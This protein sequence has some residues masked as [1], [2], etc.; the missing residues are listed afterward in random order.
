[1]MPEESSRTSKCVRCRF[2]EAP[3][4]DIT[5]TNKRHHTKAYRITQSDIQTHICSEY[6]EGARS[7][8][9]IEENKSANW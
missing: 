9:S 5:R 1:M 3:E 4:L 8:A 2:Y 7:P 6:N